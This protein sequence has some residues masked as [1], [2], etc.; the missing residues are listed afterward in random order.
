MVK[1]A[2]MVQINP[3]DQRGQMLPTRVPCVLKYPVTM[4]QIVANFVRRVILFTLPAGFFLSLICSKHIHG[5]SQHAKAFNTAVNSK[6][7]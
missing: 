6:I 5:G 3:N 1:D 2:F 7:F 4:H